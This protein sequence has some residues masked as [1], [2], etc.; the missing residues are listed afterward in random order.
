MTLLK[1]P[2]KFLFNALNIIAP[3]YN[4]NSVI[5]LRGVPLPYAGKGAQRYIAPSSN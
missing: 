2:K 1:R 4:L 3:T 5:V